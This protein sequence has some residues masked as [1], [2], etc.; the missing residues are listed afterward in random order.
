MNADFTPIEFE[1]LK[2]TPEEA[3]L[4][5]V[6]A[7]VFMQTDDPRDNERFLDAPKP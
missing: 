4:I 1:D 3:K 7:K 6:G 2:L 5:D